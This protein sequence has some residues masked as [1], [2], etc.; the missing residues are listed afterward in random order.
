MS[1]LHRLSRLAPAGVPL[2]FRSQQ[3]LEAWHEARRKEEILKRLR[4]RSSW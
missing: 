4:E 3:A 1:E 2:E